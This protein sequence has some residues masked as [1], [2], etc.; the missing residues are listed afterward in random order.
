MASSTVG[1]LNGRWALLFRVLM[2]GMA[3]A[4]PFLVALAVWITT[5]LFKLQ[6]DVALLRL[7]TEHIKAH[8]VDLGLHLN[9]RSNP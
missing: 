4:L 2:A 7:E 8:L 6:T 9:S 3:L 1:E 5:S